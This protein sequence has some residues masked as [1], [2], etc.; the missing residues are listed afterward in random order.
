MDQFEINTQNVNEYG[1][2]LDEVQVSPPLRTSHQSSSSTMPPPPPRRPSQNEVRPSSGE[3]GE[4]SLQTE[5]KGR[6]E[7]SWVWP[8]YERILVAGQPDGQNLNKSYH[9]C[10]L[11][12]KNMGKQP[13]P[14]FK[15]KQGGGTGTLGRHLKEK[16]GMTADNVHVGGASDSVQGQLHGYF[17]KEPG[18]GK[19]FFYNRDAMIDGF[20]KYVILDELPFNHGESSNFEEWNRTFMQPQYRRIPRNTLKRHTQQLYYKYRGHLIEMFRTIECRVSLTC[21][22]WTSFCHE[23]FIC[24]TAHWVDD[25]WYLQKRIICFEAMDESHS[26]FN[27]KTRIMTS[28]KTFNLNRK[29]FSLSLDNATC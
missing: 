28:L 16:H 20:S 14:K 25:D 18:G 26:G 6:G 8:Y 2:H 22:T 9:A 11:V 13:V 23:P 1:Q 10:C 27:L 21:D 12:C 5:T 19:P 29:V 3:D 7:T 4:G 17:G 15:W 24:V